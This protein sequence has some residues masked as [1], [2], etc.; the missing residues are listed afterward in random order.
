M[1]TKK[2]SYPGRL[3]WQL[4]E[5]NAFSVFIHHV[6]FILEI[7]FCSLCKYVDPTESLKTSA[8]LL[9]CLLDH[10]C[11]DKVMKGI[12]TFFRDTE[13]ERHEARLVYPLY[14]SL[15]IRKEP[16]CIFPSNLGMM[17]IG[18]QISQGLEASKM[19]ILKHLRSI[20]FNH[21]LVSFRHY[22]NKARQGFFGRNTS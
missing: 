11:D 5:M 16:V 9:S 14:H 3:R 2:G 22:L 10:T 19:A 8:V 18:N 17:Q 12:P 7:F 13:K 20:P 1:I 4:F 21:F 15:C 6:L